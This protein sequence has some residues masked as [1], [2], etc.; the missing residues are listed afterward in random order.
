MKI[1]FISRPTL[2]SG[3]GGDSLQVYNTANQL[4]KLGIEIDIRLSDEK[5]NYDQ[6]NL[7]HFFNI[8]RPDNI[9]HHILRCDKPFVVSTIFVD[10]SEYEK[11][12]RKGL[13][14]IIFR[15]LPADSIEYLK[16]IARFLVNGE[17]I[18]S[19][20]YLMNGQKKSIRKITKM[21]AMILP[22]SK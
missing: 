14:A 5:I 4:R 8:I 12:A 18:K 10:Y 2:F 16:A 15:L 21:A 17:K 11:K 9:L 22:N 6:Y 20:Y 19:A 3:K 7:L 13:P 1:A